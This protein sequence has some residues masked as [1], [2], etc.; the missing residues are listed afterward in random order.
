MLSC[1]EILTTMN[2]INKAK[3][4]SL[5]QMNWQQ[6]LTAT[7]VVIFCW[8]FWG[9][10]LVY[11]AQ[12]IPGSY[13]FLLPVSFLLGGVSAI[14]ILMKTM[15][16]LW[17]DL[18][19][20]LENPTSFALLFLSILLY[21][22]LLPFAEYL[23]EIVPTQGIPWLENWYQIM[24]ETFQKVFDY[25]IASFLTICILAPI[26]EEILFRGIILRGML[27]K[28]LSPIFAIFFSSILFG[29]AHLNP[30][31]FLGA[32]FLGGIIGFV[33]YRTKSLWLAIFLHA[34][35]N[36]ISF[37]YMMK[38]ESLEKNVSNLDHT[39]SII[40]LFMAG[41]ICGW[42]MYKLTQNKQ[43]WN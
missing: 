4:I 12:Y 33:Y 26:L 41:L 9:M 37:Y 8:Q 38:Y 23:T 29:L 3:P 6:A 2:E 28:G 14:F 19:N 11:P 20:H 10:L 15:K 18:R 40:L 32:G 1:K 43:Q 42:T 30:W 7:F 34:L 13:N 36:M 35:N 39:T 24:S 21:L 5:F 25:P 16:L 22:F 31:Q 27:Q 17:K